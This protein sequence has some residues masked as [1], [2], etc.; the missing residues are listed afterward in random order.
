MSYL[1]TSFY[2][3]L[4]NTFASQPVVTKGFENQVPYVI[5]HNDETTTLSCRLA[6]YTTSRKFIYDRS[7]ETRKN[8]VPASSDED[9]VMRSRCQNKV[10]KVL[11]V[12]YEFSTCI[13][14]PTKWIYFSKKQASTLP[15]SNTTSYTAYHMAT[16]T[17][18]HSEKVK[19]LYRIV[20]SETVI[21]AIITYPLLFAVSMAAPCAIS[22]LATMSWP[23]R[24]AM[25]RLVLPWQLTA[26]T[27]TP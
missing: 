27:S 26:S 7:N 13:D 18:Y 1:H 12:I 19:L 5:C 22:S 4:P 10:I 23:F 14:I 6:Q 8:W 9:L 2:L 20:W 21:K 11:V 24:Q 17:V 3:S 15:A 16:A 25:C